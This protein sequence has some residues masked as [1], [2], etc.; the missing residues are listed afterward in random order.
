MVDKNESGQN[1][2]ERYGHVGGCQRKDNSKCIRG[3]PAVGTASIAFPAKK[4]NRG[5]KEGF[6]AF[7]LTGNF[8]SL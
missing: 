5:Q 1:E 3:L 2:M 8:F 6:A 4:N 7:F